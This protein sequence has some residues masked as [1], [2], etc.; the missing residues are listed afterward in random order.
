MI[1]QGDIIVAKSRGGQSSARGPDPAH[2]SVSSGLLVTAKSTT[3]ISM[4]INF[5]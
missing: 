5:R 1:D 4:E 3:V 2:S